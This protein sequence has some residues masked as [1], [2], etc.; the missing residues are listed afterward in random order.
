MH[1]VL[2][3]VLDLNFSFVFLIPKKKS[4]DSDRKIL[5]IYFPVRHSMALFVVIQTEKNHGSQH[6]SV[7]YKYYTNQ[8][9][10]QHF[11]NDQHGALS[12]VEEH[13]KQKKT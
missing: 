13:L 12:S 9:I 10:F 3:L 1:K 6:L 8:H 2:N 11:G 5:T 7:V 4:R